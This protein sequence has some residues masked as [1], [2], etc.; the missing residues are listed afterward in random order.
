MNTTQKHCEIADKIAA[1]TFWRT[2][3]DYKNLA[4]SIT[5]VLDTAH[6]DGYERGVRESAIKGNKSVADGY[7]GSHIA[8]CIL[9]LIPPPPQVWKHKSTCPTQFQ[10]NAKLQRWALPD[11]VDGITEC[12]HKSWHYCPSCGAA[13]PDKEGN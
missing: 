11:K 1:K 3:E 4:A 13:R 5:A 6:Q 2:S 12:T 9:S 7:T 10:W 8:R